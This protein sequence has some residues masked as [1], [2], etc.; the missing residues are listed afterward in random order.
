M[1]THMLNTRVSRRADRDN[2]EWRPRDPC[3]GG[4]AGRPLAGGQ[5]RRDTDGTVYVAL[6]IRHKGIK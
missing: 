4:A 3:H 2:E 6:F 1:V 5:G